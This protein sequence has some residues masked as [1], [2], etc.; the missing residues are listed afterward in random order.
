M[1]L[2]MSTQSKL[3]YSIQTNLCG[4]LKCEGMKIKNMGCNLTICDGIH[5]ALKSHDS[6]YMELKAENT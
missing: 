2:T 3:G 4:G 6:F 1:N 5:L